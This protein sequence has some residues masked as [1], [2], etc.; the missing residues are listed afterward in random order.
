LAAFGASALL[1]PD[2]KTHFNTPQHP[3]IYTNSWVYRRI[4]L[5]AAN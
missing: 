3:P 5:V 1:R 2:Q 4:Q